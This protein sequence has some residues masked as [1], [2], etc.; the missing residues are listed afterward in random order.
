MLQ[1][2]LWVS[3]LE[4]GLFFGL[5]ALAYYLVF[6]GAG[7]FNFAIGGYAMLA[8]VA[9]SWMTTAHGVAGWLAALL[10]VGTTMAVAVLTEVA[11]VRP[12]QQR[13]G[14]G[15]LPA[16]VAVAATLFTLQELAGTLFGFDPFPPPKVIQLDAFTAGSVHIGS[17]TLPLLGGALVCFAAVALWTGR[18]RSGRLMR[19]IG[20]DTGVARL[21][22]LP[23][24]R[25]RI[26]VFLAA[27]LIAGVAGLLFAA[28]SGVGVGDGLKWTLSG[29][30]AF[31]IGGSGS[32]WAPLLGGLL[33]GIGYVFIPLY[34][35][36]AAFYYALVA[37][38]MLFF[39]LRPEGIFVRR[40]RV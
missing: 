6:L 18:T 25:T 34:L 16:L 22:G 17:A 4:I 32:V 5:L 20:D 39:S 12:V 24:Q 28:K 27:G 26:L 21:L 37:V 7:L 33:L 14:R 2:Q 35:G 38:A 15:D 1:P 30:L 9:A 29:F 40:V 31:V 11:V 3:A 10:A 8:G 13:A 19:C 36:G 23:V